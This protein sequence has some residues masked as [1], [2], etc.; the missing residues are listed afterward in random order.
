MKAKRPTVPENPF[1]EVTVIVVVADAPLLM[2]SWLGEPVI[3]KLK[4]VTVAWPFS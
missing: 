1:S 4:N 3:W 2:V